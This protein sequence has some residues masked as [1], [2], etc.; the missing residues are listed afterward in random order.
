MTT[1]ELERR[2]DELGVEVFPLFDG[3]GRVFA[4]AASEQLCWFR[5]D[6]KTEVATA[7]TCEKAG[8]T[9][10]GFLSVRSYLGDWCSYC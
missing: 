8:G 4:G 5:Y 1:K 9:V 10:V 2:V 3:G 6:E 7:V